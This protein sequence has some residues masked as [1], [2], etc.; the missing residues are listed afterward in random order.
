MTFSEAEAL[1]NDIMEVLGLTELQDSPIGDEN[2]RGISGGQRKRV[3]VAIEV[4][5]KP[6]LLFLGKLF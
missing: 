2:V 6:T 3:N 4:V 1:V 5:A